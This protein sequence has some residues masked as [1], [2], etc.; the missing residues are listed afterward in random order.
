MLR[1]L[2]SGVLCAS[3]LFA[4]D[5]EAAWQ[6]QAGHDKARV[7]LDC[8][9]CDDDYLRKEITFVDYVRNR[10]DAD[11]HVLVTTQDTGGGGQQWTLKFIG[12]GASQGVDQTLIY[13]QPQ[14]ATSDETRAGFAE[15]LKL[16][17]VRYASG[18]TLA[19]RL[20]VTF[21]APEDKDA[22][23]TA[24][25]DPWNYWV[26]RLGGGGDMNGEESSNG[27]AI[28]GSFSANRTTNE[29]RISL[30]AN[31]NYRD[32]EF[33]LEDEDGQKQTILSVSR[34]LETNATVVRSITAHWSLGVL[35]SVNSQTFRNFEMKSRLASGVEYDIFPYSESTRRM[36]TVQY[37]F[38]HDYHRYREVTIYDKLQEQL[39]DHRTEV[40]LSLRQ[41]WGSS[42][43]EFSFSQYLTNPSKYSLGLFGGAE[44]RIF[45]G[46]SVEFFSEFSR[47]RDQIYLP[48][49]EASTEDILLRQRQLATG[50]QYFFDF[51]LSYSFGSIYNN[52]VNPRFGGAR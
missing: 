34:N 26:Y 18:T 50:Y 5:A 47:T 8:D 31:A 46:F 9:R 35:G 2:F 25:N 33:K 37:T 32:N 42:R 24:R 48:R 28:R 19:D 4:P 7:F 30:N 6:Q 41:P 36:L 12:L 52:I 20:H 49:G 38:G 29:W 10:E 17:L 11:V 44:I 39:L 13:N 27:H 23:A 45:K 21:K 14:T 51:G 1:R 15:I 16:G 43:A 22:K 40:G 3:I